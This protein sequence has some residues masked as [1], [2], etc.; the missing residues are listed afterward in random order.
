MSRE[1]I[2]CAKEMK[3]VLEYNLGGIRNFSHLEYTY[4]YHKFWELVAELKADVI[5]GVDAH[6]PQDF[7]D[8]E[9]IKKAEDYLKSIGIKIIDGLNIP[10]K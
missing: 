9:S 6:S 4:P 3:V 7:Y 8:T 5:I 10:I 1:I 2:Q